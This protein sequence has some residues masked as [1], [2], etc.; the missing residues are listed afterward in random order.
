[1]NT[2]DNN[3]KIARNRAETFGKSA[4]ETSSFQDNKFKSPQATYKN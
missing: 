2:P 1:M 3:E 4:N